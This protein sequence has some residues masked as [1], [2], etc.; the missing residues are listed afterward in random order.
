MGPSKGSI[1]LHKSTFEGKEAHKKL[2][3]Q[4]AEATYL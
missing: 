4:E 3:S 2:L 1:I